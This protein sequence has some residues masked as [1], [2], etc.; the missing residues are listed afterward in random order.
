MAE[1]LSNQYRRAL[2]ADR[3]S[4]DSS[5]SAA[6][7]YDPVESDQAEGD[8]QRRRRM[9]DRFR[10]TDIDQKALQAQTQAQLQEAVK[11][12]AQQFLSRGLARILGVACG[13][14]IILLIV[15]YI[16]MTIQLIVGNLLGNPLVPKLK[17]WEQIVWG[18]VTFLIFCSFIMN[19][20]FIL[21]MI[22]MVIGPVASFAL[23]VWDTLTN[24]VGL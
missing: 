17:L 2:F 20:A 14:T 13:S 10:Q 6:F 1:V 16:I 23:G 7:D 18:V 8:E 3:K 24:L 15:P 11:T 21:L 12:K 4:S 9:L 19:I 5:N 22:K